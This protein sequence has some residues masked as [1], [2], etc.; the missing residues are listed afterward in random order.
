M[1]ATGA[2]EDAV[3][4]AKRLEAD[5]HRFYL[6]AAGKASSEST[7]KMFAALAGDEARHLEWLEELAPGVGSAAEANRALYGS[8]KDVFGGAS[9][10]D[11]AR[12]AGSD[13]EA[14]DFAIGIED[15]SIAAYSEWAGKGENEEIRKLG[16]VL[17]GQE[18]FHRQLLE[19][20]KEYLESPGDWFMQDERWNFE[21]G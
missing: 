3:S 9:G 21:G 19:N 6:D 17:V 20:A 4:S 18:R 13:I 8:L 11:V 16:G 2:T 14:I 7:R 5:G 15:K 1:G 10:A 12:D